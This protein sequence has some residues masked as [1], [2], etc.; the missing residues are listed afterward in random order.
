MLQKLVIVGGALVTAA[1][2]VSMGI[3]Y[4][5]E[6]RERWRFYQHGPEVPP[7]PTSMGQEILQKL[8]ADRK[9][10]LAKEY[11]RIQVSLNQ[12]RARG[13][14][15]DKLQRTMDL[16][17][18]LGQQGKYTNAQ[19]M[20]NAVEMQIPKKAETFRAAGDEEGF[21]STHKAVEG[22]PV[23]VQKKAPAKKKRKALRRGSP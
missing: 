14:N 16:A 2:A 18:Q 23:G 22:A 11:G 1:F 3:T 17:M 21:V 15:V 8:D 7:K 5:D 4:Q 20:L 19:Q 13:A 6:L 9:K 10:E 12:A